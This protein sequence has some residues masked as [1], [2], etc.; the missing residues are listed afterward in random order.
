MDNIADRTRLLAAERAKLK[1]ELRKER[2]KQRAEARQWV[3]PEAVS[4][5][6]LILF[7]LAQYEAEPVVVYLEALARQY[8]WPHRSAEELRIFVEDAFISATSSEEG[9][10]AFARLTDTTNPSDVAAMTTAV[11]RVIEWRSVAWARDKNERIGLAPSSASMLDRAEATRATLPGGVRPEQRGTSSEGRNRK[12]CARLRTRFKGRFGK[13]KVRECIPL[14]EMQDKARATHQWFNYLEDQLPPG[15]RALRINLDET[16]VCAFQGGA[17]GNVFVTK[18]KAAVENAPL[19]KRRCCLTHVAVIC[20][21]ADLQPLMPQFV[22]GNERTLRQADMPAL[23]ASCGPNVHLI[24]QKSAWNNTALCLRIVR[25]LRTVLLPYLHAIQPFLLMDTARLHLGVVLHACLRCGIW[26]ILVPPK[27][28]WLLQ[29]L[30][31]D[32]LAMFKHIL[33]AAYQRARAGDPDGNVSIA[34]LIRCINEA[35]RVV[36]QGRHWAAVFDGDGFGARQARVSARVLQHLE[37]QCVQAPS[38]KPSLAQ[39][40]LCFPRRTKVIP[41][42]ALLGCGGGA[43]ARGRGAGRGGVAAVRGRGAARGVFGGRGRG[44]CASRTRSGCVYKP[45]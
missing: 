42:D 6:S 15:K 8:D 28:T 35:V 44:D 43:A 33:R 10:D 45:P 39:I 32:G 13:L 22:I 27:L 14:P 17:S 31:T 24:R 26:P 37:L 18:R 40:R 11:R 25:A 23:R 41:Y 30:D 29:P 1:K 21:R 3:L 4:H 7:D 19:A 38:A 20:D 9:L 12:W 5:T 34:E 36:L 2:D 16:A